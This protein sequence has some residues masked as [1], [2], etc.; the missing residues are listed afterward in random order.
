[1]NATMW[2]L[3]ATVIGSAAAL[4]VGYFHR[5][6]Q[7]EI[8]AFKAGMTIEQIRPKSLLN[9]HKILMVFVWFA[10]MESLTIAG[11][12]HTMT[13][14]APVTK[15]M[16]LRIAISVG[17]VVLNLTLFLLFIL[18]ELLFVGRK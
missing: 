12:V 16:I 3:I 14:A 5:R 6:N 10:L 7:W 4:T 13:S 17:V 2:T 11:L 8:E 18:G 1:M 9:W 15:V